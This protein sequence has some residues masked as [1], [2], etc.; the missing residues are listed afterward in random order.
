M[1]FV[2]G[3]RV[4]GDPRTP[5]HQH[6]LTVRPELVVH[7]ANEALHRRTVAAGALG[8]THGGVDEVD[9]QQPVR[10]LGAAAP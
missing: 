8:L 10:A 6:E 4:L 7:G 3:Q 5:V 1:G 2:A 9:C